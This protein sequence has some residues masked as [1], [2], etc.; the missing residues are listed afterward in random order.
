[1]KC[2]EVMEPDH[3]EKDGKQA[4]EWEEAKARVVAL[5]AAKAEEEGPAFARTVAREY[6]IGRESPV[7]S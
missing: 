3:R 1:M 5:V 7:S 4:G 6:P 2:P